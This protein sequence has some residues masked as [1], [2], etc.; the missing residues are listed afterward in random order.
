MPHDI[1]ISYSRRNL[2]AVKS[3][4]EELESFG[5]SCW[6]DLEGIESGSEEFTRHI[7]AA[8]NGSKAF[9]FFLSAASQ[10]SE[11]SLKELRF[12]KDKGKRTVVVRFNDAAMTDVFSFN[13][14][15]D[16]IVDWRV[17]DQ[18]SKLLQDLARWSRK[19][20]PEP[21]PEEETRPA[22]RPRSA[23]KA[24]KNLPIQVEFSEALVPCSYVMT[25][26]NVSD[27]PVDISIRVRNGTR[28]ASYDY[29]IDG[30]HSE[31][32]RLLGGSWRFTD[33]DTGTIRVAGWRRRLKFGI[34]EDGYYAE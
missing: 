20:L 15:G 32:F 23:K 13:F 18:K 22:P 5:F 24:E 12:A 1:F 27:D 16:D 2:N 28:E 9:L 19:S 4:K 25:V 10:A 26:K 17:S 34:D 29:S 6:M 31:D 3:I 8:I 14:G 11:W 30:G 7:T 21:E 33:G